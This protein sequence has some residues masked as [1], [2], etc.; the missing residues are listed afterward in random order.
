MKYLFTL[1]TVLCSLCS[2]GQTIKQGDNLKTEYK[3]ISKPYFFN[4]PNFTPWIEGAGILL[5]GEKPKATDCNF[6]FLALKDTTLIGVFK[7]S[8][9]PAFIFDTEGNSTISSVSQTFLLPSWVVK[10]KTKINGSDKTVLT[11]LDKLYEKTLQA[12]EL[13]LDEKTMQDYQRYQEDTTL[14]NRHIVLLFDNY[15]TII[16]ETAEKGQK[17]PADVC[18]PLMNSLANEC[19]ALYG[20]IPVMVCIYLGE[21]FESAGMIDDAKKQFKKSLELYPNSIPLLVY[22]YKF[23]QEPAKKKEKLTE[24]KKKYP[25]H[26]MVKDL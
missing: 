15:Q 19:M 22:N 18:V 16:T 20:K 21:A 11:L 8:N 24:L 12:N 13:E 10:R 6:L 26:W 3:K 5:I 1:V 7:M 9:P 25:Q 23:E 2:I 4:G 14:A 17:P